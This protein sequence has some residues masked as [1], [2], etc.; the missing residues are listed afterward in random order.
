MCAPESNAN[1]CGRCARGPLQESA[2]QGHCE[3]CLKGATPENRFPG[4]QP[5]NTQ[6]LRPKGGS[7]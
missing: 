2:D 5:K 4:F 7:A 3:K 1:N 6:E